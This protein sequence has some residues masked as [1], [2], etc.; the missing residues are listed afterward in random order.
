MCREQHTWIGNER[1]TSPWPHDPADSVSRADEIIQCVR[2]FQ[3]GHEKKPVSPR[4]GTGV[5]SNEMGEGQTSHLRRLM[6]E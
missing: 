4:P 6:V 5:T 2:H 1:C 3:K